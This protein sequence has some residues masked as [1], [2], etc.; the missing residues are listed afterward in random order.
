MSSVKRTCP[1][2][3]N[4]YV[5]ELADDV[6]GYMNWQMGDYVQD[7]FPQSTA[8]QREQLLSGIC[9]DACWSMLMGEDDPQSVWNATRSYR[10]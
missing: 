2:C 10:E 8:T 7:A 9:S 3:K 5:P 6:V 4:E 1:C